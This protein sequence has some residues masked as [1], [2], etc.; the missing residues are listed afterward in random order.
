LQSN[1]LLTN[2]NNKERVNNIIL[3]I[4]LKLILRQALF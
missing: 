3:Y 4:L 2:I 1:S